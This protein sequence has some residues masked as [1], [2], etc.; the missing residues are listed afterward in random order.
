VQLYDRL[1]RYCVISVLTLFIVIAA[2]RP[3]NK[4]VSTEAVI[5]AKRGEEPGIHKLLANYQSGGYKFRPMSGWNGRIGSQPFVYEHSLNPLKR[6]D[7]LG[8]S[9][10]Q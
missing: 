8:H 5:I 10:Q 3:V 6:D 4:N 2:S 1:K 9:G 7:E